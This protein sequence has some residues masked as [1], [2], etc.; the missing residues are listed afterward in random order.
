[1]T[2]TPAPTPA[3]GAGRWVHGDDVLAHATSAGAV[4]APASGGPAVA[5]SGPEAML[6]QATAEPATTETLASLV[7]DDVARTGLTALAGLGILRE[8]D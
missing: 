6:W 5:L 8:V 2:T 7:G 3:A 4:V 1:M